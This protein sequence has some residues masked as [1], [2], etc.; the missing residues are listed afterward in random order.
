MKECVERSKLAPIVKLV[1]HVNRIIAAICFVIAE[2]DSCDQSL[3]Q[4]DIVKTLFLADK[5]HL[6]D[7]GR[8]I[9]FDNYCAM[10]HGPVPTLAYDFLKENAAALQKY[11]IK[12]L[13][14][15]RSK[16]SGSR[17]LYKSRSGKCD[18]SALSLSD[19]EALLGALSVI[20]S[21][22]F[23]QIRQITHN[24]QAYI[25]AWSDEGGSCF[26]MN[27]A[28]MFDVPN[29]EAAENLSFLSKNQ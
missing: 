11:G 8:P 4:Y 5:K 20:K 3:T 26:P 14:W 24:D 16:G 21:L 22:T 10:Q 18:D 19:K 17:Y 29:I 12:K 23:S 7:F 27:L 6:N 25:Q 1:P 15:R 2:A 28:F 13:P 9:T